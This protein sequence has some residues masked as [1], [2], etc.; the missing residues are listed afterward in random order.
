[1]R[2][3][4]LDLGFDGTAGLIASYLIES[5]SELA[6]IETGPGSCLP[7]AVEELAERGVAVETIRKVFVSHVH[8]DHAGAAGWWAQQGAQVFCHPRA[9]RHLIDPSRL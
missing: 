4:T 6:L 7:R 9:A 3:Q 8:L 5:D 1:M 2:I